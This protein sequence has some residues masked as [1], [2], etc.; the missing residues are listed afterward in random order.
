MSATENRRLAE[1]RLRWTRAGVV[2]LMFGLSVISYF[3]RTIMSI[4]GPSMMTEFGITPAKMGTVYS[5]FLFSYTLLM[6]PAGRLADRFGPRKV[7][8]WMAFGSAL[9]TAL[10]AVAGKPGLGSLMGILPALLLVRLC[11]GVFTAPLY[12]T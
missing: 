12:P 3:D 7:L 4:A 10:V 11:A 1:H 9:F 5:A 8:A 6:I 2:A